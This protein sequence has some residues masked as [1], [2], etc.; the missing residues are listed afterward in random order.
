MTIEEQDYIDQ[1]A[2]SLKATLLRIAK[3]GECKPKRNGRRIWDGHGERILAI[4]LDA[5]TIHPER[6]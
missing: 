4:A 6:N 5:F 1:N 3:H 2:A